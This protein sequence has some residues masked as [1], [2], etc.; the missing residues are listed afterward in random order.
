MTMCPTV[1]AG[2]SD[3]VKLWKYLLSRGINFHWEDDPASWVD[4]SGKPTLTKREAATIRRLFREAIK[5][6]DERCFDDA[7]SLLKLSIVLGPTLAIRVPARRARAF[8][9]C[10]PAEMRK[11]YSR[12]PRALQGAGHPQ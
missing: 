6:D 9:A 12:V 4:E 7:I 1:V 2:R 3:A 11:L 10:D 8:D 5:L